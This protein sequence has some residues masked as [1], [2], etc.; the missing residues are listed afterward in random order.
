MISSYPVIFST[1]IIFSS[2]VS[3]ALWLLVIFVFAFVLLFVFFLIKNIYSETH[4]TM[5]NMMKNDEKNMIKKFHPA[6][7]QKQNYFFLA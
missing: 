7:F 1:D 4:S 3:L 6:D 5:R 2:L